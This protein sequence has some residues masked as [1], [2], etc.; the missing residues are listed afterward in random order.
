[1]KIII[2]PEV[3]YRLMAY[4]AITR[5]EYSGFGFC[6]RQEGNI[7]VYDFVLLDVGDPVYTEIDPARVLP[8]LSRPDRKNMKV[9]LHRHPV[10]NGIP[11]PHNW[12][13]RDEL[14]IQREPLGSTREAANW[15]VSIVLTPGGFVGRVDNY[16]KGI[17]QHLE[18]EPNTRSLVEEVRELASQLPFEKP[19]KKRGKKSMNSPENAST[20]PTQFPSQESRK[21]K[22]KG[23]SRKK[24][25]SSTTP[26]PSDGQET[27]DTQTYMKLYG[28]FAGSTIQLASPLPKSAKITGS[29]GAGNGTDTTGDKEPFGE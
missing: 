19:T 5:D 21:I 28:S 13:G 4:A 15:S 23:K 8:L 27:M 24:K 11:G 29:T 3:M 16:V 20:E 26:S 7:I 18:V 2:K 12:S 6:E 17:T 25:T 9:W 14:T 10:G 1:M 22:A